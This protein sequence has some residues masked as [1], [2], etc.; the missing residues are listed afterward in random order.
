MLDDEHGHILT[1]ANFGR[2]YS[3]K[4]TYCYLINDLFFH[5]LDYCATKYVNACKFMGK[6]VIPKHLRLTKSFH[7][8]KVLFR[9]YVKGF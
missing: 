3:F 4:S 6:K 5:M 1:N 2:M 9:Q 7:I 8:V